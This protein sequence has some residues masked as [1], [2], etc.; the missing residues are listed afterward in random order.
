MFA[1]PI[2]AIA[3]PN[4]QQI[5]DEQVHQGTTRNHTNQKVTI[6]QL[7]EKPDALLGM[8]FFFGSGGALWASGMVQGNVGEIVIGLGLVGAAALCAQ[9]FKK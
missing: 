5:T 4:Q 3:L 2:G 9:S 7:K 8:G 1:V 6:E